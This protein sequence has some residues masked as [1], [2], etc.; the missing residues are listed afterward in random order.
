MRI[1]MAI[2]MYPPHFF[3]RSSDSTF[4][5]DAETLFGLKLPHASYAPPPLSPSASSQYSLS[6]YLLH[7]DPLSPTQSISPTRSLI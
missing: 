2:E 1:G 7:Y 3:P 4:T 5:P 6:T